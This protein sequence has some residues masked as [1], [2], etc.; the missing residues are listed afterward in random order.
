[1]NK[2]TSKWDPCGRKKQPKNV[3]WPHYEISLCIKFQNPWV[4]FKAFSTWASRSHYSSLEKF[5]V[6][7]WHFEKGFRVTKMSSLS[8]TMGHA[9][10]REDE[11]GRRVRYYFLPGQAEQTNRYQ[12]LPALS[13]KDS[14]IELSAKHSTPPEEDRDG[15][16]RGYR[17][18]LVNGPTFLSLT[19][20][21]QSI[22]CGA[23]V[24]N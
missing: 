5:S 24:I 11:R 14:L 18:L 22:G 19:S 23:F 17:L 2:L 12:H 4:V 16:L 9:D 10:Q 8:F 7:S 6:G 20:T 1:M 13:K 15:C 21:G 3:Q